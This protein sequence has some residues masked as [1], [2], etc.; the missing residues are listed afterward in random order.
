MSQEKVNAYK[1]KKATRKADIEKA[2]KKKK[3]GKITGRLI[4]IVIGAALVFAL[5]LTA[6]NI[7]KGIKAAQPDYTKNEKVIYE[8]VTSSADIS[9][10]VS[11]DGEVIINDSGE[12]PDAEASQEESESAVESESADESESASESAAESSESSAD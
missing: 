1:E 6:I 4:A 12:T 8:Y 2:K 3:A 9:D 11:G 5:V 7:I 10:L